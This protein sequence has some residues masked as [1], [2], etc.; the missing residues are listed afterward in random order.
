M[1]S[2][3]LT[4]GLPDWTPVVLGRRD[5]GK[6]TDSQD[7]FRFW[8]RKVDP[9]QENF[10]LSAVFE[11]EDA[12]GVGFQTGYGI[13]AVDTVVNPLSR[14]RHR[15]HA[16][17]GRFRTVSGS[18]YGCGLRIVGG[19]SNRWALPQ[20]GRRRLDPSRQFPT[21]DPEDSIGPG[22]RHRFT[23]TKTDAGL[24]ASMETPGGIET[25]SFPGCDFLLKQDRRFIYVGFAIAGKVR[26]R[27]TDIRF[28]TAPGKLSHTPDS[29]IGHFVPDYPF[30]RT[31][32]PDS[33]SP[34]S[35]PLYEAIRRAGPGS[36][37]ILP[38][39]VYPGPVVIPESCSGE[40]GR[41]VILRAE[42]PGKAVID[43]SEMTA[44]LPAMTLRGRFWI[45]D[46]LVFRNAPS[47]GLFL[48]GSDNVIRHC[49]ASGNGDTGIL[50]CAFPGSEKKD[51]PAGN[52]VESCLSHDNC[53]GVRH[54][55]DGFGAK[56]SAGPGN[57]FVS[58]KAFHNI[59]DGFDLYTKNS[60]GPIGAVTLLDCEAAFNGWLSSEEKP[61]GK[62]DT[63][64]GFKLGGEH[65]RVRH[66]LENCIA[67]DN[68][69]GGFKANSNP[70][71]RLIRCKAW[72]N[73]LP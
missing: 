10:T 17:L 49:E 50:I 54:N 33:L 48:C 37:I 61:D 58:C 68:A 2:A 53:D 45:L 35:G 11:V 34:A 66:I 46:G 55:A 13:M 26:L 42:H 3:P 7:S 19:Y 29:A 1:G 69:R 28:E 32:L 20:D 21:Q 41:P 52:R 59:D 56:L 57:V 47:S 63:G 5:G 31:L 12:G 9:R 43:G 60:L 67:H 4:A 72:N 8:Y 38:D 27:I 71:C 39:G 16:L 70:S 15:N 65:Q 18:N 40:P 22:D 6:L 73:P 24:E 62:P 25:L 14:C 44:K 64:I 51:W 23:L 36:E 30:D